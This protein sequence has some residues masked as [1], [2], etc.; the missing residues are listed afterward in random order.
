[1]VVYHNL[2]KFLCTM[3]NILRILFY[4]EPNIIAWKQAVQ[5][6]KCTS[7]IKHLLHRS[8][9]NLKLFSQ[10]H[11]LPTDVT[12]HHHTRGNIQQSVNLSTCMS[13]RGETSVWRKWAQKQ[14]ML[15]WISGLNPGD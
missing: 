1:M 11:Q 15:L 8:H 9:V 10:S 2:V 3:K 4:H 12:T 13:L 5:S 6:K 7:T 14:N